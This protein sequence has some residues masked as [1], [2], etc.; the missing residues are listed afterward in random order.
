MRRKFYIIDL[1]C[2]NSVWEGFVIFNMLNR[3]DRFSFNVKMCG[4]ILLLLESL[5]FGG[6]L[7]FLVIF[8]LLLF[9]KF[10]EY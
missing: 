9:L 8:F 3:N 7:S 5:Y 6:V 4:L 2:S 10:F 1:I